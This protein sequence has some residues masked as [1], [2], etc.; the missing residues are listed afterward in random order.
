[1]TWNLCGVYT[2]RLTIILMG[3]GVQFFNSGQAFLLE[4][5]K[6]CFLSCSSHHF[7]RYDVNEFN[8]FLVVSPFSDCWKRLNNLVDSLSIHG[9]YSLRNHFR[10]CF[11]VVAN[12]VT[13]YMIIIFCL[14]VRNILVYLLIQI[15]DC[16]QC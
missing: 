9:I 2:S 12:T 8:D 10:M 1:M 5:L 11:F 3:V 6:S 13:S 16:I 4:N 14:L 15:C 7:L